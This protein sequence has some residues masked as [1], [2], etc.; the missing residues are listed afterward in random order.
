MDKLSVSED[1]I[2]FISEPIRTNDYGN[3]NEYIF[4]NFTYPLFV[5]EIKGDTNLNAFIFQNYF[6][7]E[8]GNSPNKLIRYKF[9]S[10]ESL[11]SFLFNGLS[12][13]YFPTPYYIGYGSEIASSYTNHPLYSGS[14]AA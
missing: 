5:K 14:G 9:S 11:F 3:S 8:F 1:D 7:G 13:N 10:E 4:K 12:A 6:D 2:V